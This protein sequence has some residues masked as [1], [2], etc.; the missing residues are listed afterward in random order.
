MSK[1]AIQEYEW[2]ITRIKSNPAAYV[3]RVYAPDAQTAIKRAIAE[4]EITNPEH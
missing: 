4:F 3:G 2:R 1:K